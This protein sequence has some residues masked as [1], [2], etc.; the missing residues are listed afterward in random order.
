MAHHEEAQVAA[1]LLGAVAHGSYLECF[2]KNRDPLFWE[3]QTE[4]RPIRNGY[5]EISSAPGLGISLDRD[6]VARYRVT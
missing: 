6:Y 4:P 5:Y 3:I 1:H 2:H